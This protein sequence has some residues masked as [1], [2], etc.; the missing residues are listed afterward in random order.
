MALIEDD[1]VHPWITLRKAYFL[2]NIT[3]VFS[4]AGL[5]SVNMLLWFMMV[6]SFRTH[7]VR[8]NWVQQAL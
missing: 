6:N 5:A 2:L 3:R 4:I 1:D 7:T 8:I